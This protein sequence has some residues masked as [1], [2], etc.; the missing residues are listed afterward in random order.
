MTILFS[1][2]V[3]SFHE[4]AG[5]ALKE[6]G[7]EGVSPEIMKLMVAVAEIMSL[8]SAAETALIG[9]VRRRWAK[10]RFYEGMR[11]YIA[12]PR[13]KYDA[14][15][16]PTLILETQAYVVA[17]GKVAPPTGSSY[18]VVVAEAVGKPE[19]QL[20]PLN[21]LYSLANGSHYDY[22]VL[23]RDG[24]WV[25]WNMVGYDKGVRLHSELL[26]GIRQALRRQSVDSWLRSF[27]PQ[28]AA[29][30]PYVVGYLL[31]LLS[32]GMGQ[33]PLQGGQGFSNEE[34][35]AA[36]KSFGYNE[37]EAKDMIRPALPQLAGAGSLEEA[38]RIIL[39]AYGDG[40]AGGT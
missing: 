18:R 35:V 25:T 13:L 34:L 40:K 27:G 37:T 3:D 31:G 14:R 1:Q 29:L 10:A 32:R 36:I 11:Y 39:K 2:S 28:G 30:A 38:V 26:D 23:E 5:L 4:A 15:G 7:I 9:V 21:I 6:A 17:S 22:T 8:R 19:R 12:V 16:I 20:L 33:H 24:P